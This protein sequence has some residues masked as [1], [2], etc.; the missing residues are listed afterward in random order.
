ML[1]RIDNFLNKITMYRLV[2]YSL[3]FM[4]FG[5]VILAF[6]KILAFD[7][8]LFLIGIVFLTIICLITNKIFSVVF[9]APTN[10]ESA[11]ITALIL[12]LIIDPLS[13]LNDFNTWMFFFWVAIWAM[14]SKYIFAIGKKHLF[15]PVVVA[16]IITSFAIGEAAS[17]WIGTL[18]MAPFV[19]IGGLLIT[20]KIR[21][22]DLVL[23]FFVASIVTI[24]VSKA[25]GFLNAFDLSYKTIFYSPFLFLAFVMLT[26]PLTTPPRRVLRISYGALVGYLA[27][28]TQSF[29]G[30]SLTP[31]IGLL[32]GNLFSYIVSPKQKLIL[33]LKDR[34]KVSENTYDFI[35]ESKRRLNFRPGQYLEWTL[36]HDKPDSRGNRRYFTIAS[37]PTEADIRMGIRF[38]PKGSSYKKELI[39]L[40]RGDILVASQLAGEFVLPR[41][42]KKKLVFIAGGIGITP[43]RSMIKY[44]IDTKQKRDIVLFYSNR[45]MAD[46]TY[47]DLLNQASREIGLKVVCTL[48]DEKPM[49]GVWNGKLGML[50]GMM[51]M[52]NVPDFQDRYYYVS[53]THGMV[54]AFDDTLQKMGIPKKHINTDF[55]PGFA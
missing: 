43:F 38:Y 34:I 18:V 10:V 30:M 33:K 6:F 3:C 39:S 8:I 45:T 55:F 44:L 16:V 47:V 7:P 21:R 17:W 11:Y 25:T 29:F 5:A 42:K 28:T 4:A 12:A 50:N 46:T 26:E 15:N 52:E 9:E 22:F 54:N 49:P 14:A 31:E 19:I 51:I 27:T 20:R 23:S 24:I 13:K 48:T 2:L 32:I 37:S 41:N 53:G 35:F 40:K 1:R 36:D